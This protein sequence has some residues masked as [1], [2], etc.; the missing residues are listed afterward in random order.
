VR[1][2]EAGDIAQT[3]SRLAREA[4]LFLGKDVV[5]A[6]ER[7]RQQEEAPLGLWVLDQVL[8]NARISSA[9]SLPLCQD[10]GAAVVL[11]DVGQDAH[12]VGG[13]LEAA[14]QD[15]IRQGYGEGYLRKSMVRQPF[16]AR[17][18]TRDN[19]PAIIHT[20]IVPGDKLKI[21]LMPKGGGAENKS[22]LFMLTPSRGRQGVIE[23]VL[24]AVED[25]GSDPCPPIIVG[26]GIGGT[27]EKVMMLAKQA[28]TREV[29]APNPDPETASLEQ[30]LLKRVNELGIGPQGLGGRV[31]ALAVHV[32]V[33]PAH[34]AS[35]PVGVNIQCH[36]AR[37]K[38]AI[39]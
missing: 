31:T 23:S 14:V 4:N 33:F 7:A 37:H 22:R 35:L 18:N 38:E 10:C 17:V 26:V 13:D 28:L 29:G 36:S 20:R 1:E 6:L 24:T 19:T 5:H 39:L 2:I 25:A 32:E 11:L 34:I 12:V 30:E 3:V 27:S 15:G 16:S 8:E 21:T 9:G